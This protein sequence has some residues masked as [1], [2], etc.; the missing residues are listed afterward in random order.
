VYLKP[1]SPR[2]KP[3]EEDPSD[4]KRQQQQKLRAAPTVKE[5]TGYYI[6]K[7]AKVRK[8]SWRED[9]RILNYNI[10]PA[11]GNLKAH[12]VSRKMVLEILDSIVKRGAPVQ[13]NRVLSVVRKMYNFACTRE[14]VENS[15]CI[16]ITRPTVERR[17]DRVLSAAELIK[18]F[19]GLEE[20]KMSD[21]I[22]LTV[23]LILATGQRRALVPVT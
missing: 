4:L 20:S 17:R 14:V 12:L 10:L 21:L 8:K 15:P 5:L 3:W 19:S 13:A 16:G 11:I 22:R 23:K 7:W 6:E 18:F 2:Q 9:Q 1:I